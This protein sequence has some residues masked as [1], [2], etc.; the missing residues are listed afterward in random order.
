VIL[1]KK[2]KQQSQQKLYKRGSSKHFDEI[3]VAGECYM[4]T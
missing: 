3:V 4:M 1:V 2:I